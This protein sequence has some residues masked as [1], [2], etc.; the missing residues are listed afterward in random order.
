MIIDKIWWL[1]SHVECT[2]AA[3]QALTTFKQL[4]PGHRRKEVEHCIERAALFI[5]KIQ[6][7]DGSWLVLLLCLFTF[8]LHNHHFFLPHHLPYCDFLLS[9]QLPSG[10]W[11]ESYLSSQNKVTYLRLHVV[12]QVTNCFS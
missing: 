9:M 3:I 1:C 11:G 8:L 4:Y 10:G 5:E 6:A 7:A 2:S 12:C